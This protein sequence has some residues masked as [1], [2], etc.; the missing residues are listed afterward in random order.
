[1]P[2]EGAE[3]CHVV[4]YDAGCGLC[5]WSIAKILGWDRGGALHQVAL[6]DPEAE[7]LLPGMDSQQRMASWH[8]VTPE[9][10]VYSG[11]AAVA[12]LPFDENRIWRY[13]QRW[14]WSTVEIHPDCLGE[15]LAA[16]RDG[17][18]REGILDKIAILE[19]EPGFGRPL[20]GVL[21][22]HYRITYGRY[23]IVYRWGRASDHI[24]VW[25]IGL[26]SEE[27]YRLADRIL[28]Q[29]GVEKTG[30]RQA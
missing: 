28:R 3:R 29:R 18:A 13:I 22:G 15:D 10:R 26:R 7:W 24:L 5:R 4:L 1:M 9:G 17:R 14:Q 2:V 6:Q 12:P 20:R 27:H 11:G 8:L 16:I 21:H 23:R 30:G 25:Y 19:R